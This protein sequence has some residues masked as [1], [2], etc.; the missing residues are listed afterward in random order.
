MSDWKSLI[1]AFVPDAEAPTALGESAF[2]ETTTNALGKAGEAGLTRGFDTVSFEYLVYLD[3]L[4]QAYGLPK[5]ETLKR[6][7]HANDGTI[8]FLSTNDCRRYRKV[9]AEFAERFQADPDIAAEVLRQQEEEGIV[10][11]EQ[12]PQSEY[13]LLA[14]KRQ[15][16]ISLWRSE[17]VRAPIDGGRMIG[18]WNA[19][20]GCGYLPDDYPDAAKALFCSP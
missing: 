5:S 4:M 17:Q 2:C 9:L 13:A 16:T 12:M 10:A 18:L 1:V 11:W 6:T 7:L 20:P 3:P 15:E 8:K 14:Q 19:N